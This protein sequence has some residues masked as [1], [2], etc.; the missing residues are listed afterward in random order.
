MKNRT[1]L[2][3]IILT[4]ILHYSSAEAQSAFLANL[5]KKELGILVKEGFEN[6]CSWLSDTYVRKGQQEVTLYLRSKTAA[7][8]FSSKGHAFTHAN[9]F[10]AYYIPL[11]QDNV[12][13]QTSHLH[14]KLRNL[15]DES[16][17]YVQTHP[18]LDAQYPLRMDVYLSQKLPGQTKTKLNP[19]EKGLDLHYRYDTQSLRWDNVGKTFVITGG[20]AYAAPKVKKAVRK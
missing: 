12:Q 15:T 4:F 5:A 10:R 6:A 1:T 3:A 7:P 17:R 9:E 20:A 2:F 19:K 13:A 14:P 11:Y 18:Y 16:L 8:F